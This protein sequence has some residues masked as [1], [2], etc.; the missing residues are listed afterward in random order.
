[1]GSGT[2]LRDVD[3]DQGQHVLARELMAVLSHDLRNLLTPLRNRIDLISQRAGRENRRRDLREATEAILAIERL[4]QLVSNLLDTERLEHGLFTMR[5]ARLDLV[6]LTRETAGSLNG[7]TEIRVRAS[8]EV[9]VLADPSRLRQALENVITN[10]VQH[11]PAGEPVTVT[12]KAE[13]RAGKEWAVVTVADEGPGIPPD[14]I[15]FLFKRYQPGNGSVGLGLGLF[16]AQEIAK[17]HGGTLTVDSIPGDGTK[18][19]LAFPTGI[20]MA[21]VAVPREDRRWRLPARSSALG[22]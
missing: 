9:T 8:G 4:Q 21:G 19:R 16:L 17:A 18:F 2:N 15:P 13:R 22:R 11:S 14:R 10:G 1:M 7:T 12:V 3:L 20:A 6:R 5:P